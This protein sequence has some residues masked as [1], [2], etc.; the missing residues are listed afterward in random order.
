[1][2]ETLKTAYGTASLEDAPLPVL[3]A[4]DA[5][6]GDEGAASS[7]DVSSLASSDEAAGAPALSNDYLNHFSEVLML[8]ELACEAPDALDDLAAWRPLGYAAY[9]RVSPLRGASAALAAYEA[10]PVE[11]RAAFEALTDAMGR[12]AVGAIEALRQPDETGDAAM[13][14]LATAATLR[15]LTQRAAR[16]LASGG[17]GLPQDGE[18]ETEMQAAI[19]RLLGSDGA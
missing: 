7:N 2:A 8:I 1:L 3:E 11:R 4:I 5:T 19:D 12:L 16:F 6:V 10:L 15:R 18:A 17:D 9:F 13:A 14:A